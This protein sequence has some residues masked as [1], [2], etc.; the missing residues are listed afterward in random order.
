MQDLKN[1]KFVPRGF[2]RKR[3]QGQGVLPKDLAVSAK[4]ALDDGGDRRISSE[5]DIWHLLCVAS[6]EV[7]WS[8]GFT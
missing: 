1:R 4:T 5:S 7:F 8:G 3:T 2:Y 6:A